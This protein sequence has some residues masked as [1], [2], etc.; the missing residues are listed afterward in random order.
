MIKT[1]ECGASLGIQNLSLGFAIKDVANPPT[2]DLIRKSP[3]SSASRL[4][5]HSVVG[6]AASNAG[7]TNSMRR[8]ASATR[9][10]SAT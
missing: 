9:Y 6:G 8:N 4:V 10:A 5:G 3:I 1:D 7:E 2:V